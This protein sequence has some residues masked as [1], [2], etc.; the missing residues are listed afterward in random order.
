MQKISRHCDV[1]FDNSD[2]PDHKCK[3]RTAREM[4]AVL[5]L[6][7]EEEMKSWSIRGHDNVFGHLN[8]GEAP[9]GIWGS[10]P[11]DPTHAFRH[12]LMAY[13]LSILFSNLNT[14]QLD[15]IDLYGRNI[16]QQCRQSGSKSFPR[17]TFSHGITSLTFM[18]H[19]EKVGITMI[20]AMIMATER[21]HE[22]LIEDG[23]FFETADQVNDWLLLFEMFLCFDAWTH[24]GTMWQL[25]VDRST[26]EGEKNLDASIRHMLSH[27]SRTCERHEGNAWKLPKY[28]E[29]LHVPWYISLFGHPMNF[30]SGRCEHNHIDLCKTPGATAQKRNDVFE[31]QTGMR[32]AHRY[33][34]DKAKRVWNI[35]EDQTEKVGE[36]NSTGARATRF[37]V[38]KSPGNND[39]PVYDHL[40][41]GTNNGLLR[42]DQ[43]VVALVGHELIDGAEGVVK[44]MTEY[45]RSGVTYRS[46]PKYR[47]VGPWVDWVFVD[48]Q[49]DD[50]DAPGEIITETYPCK[51]LCFAIRDHPVEMEAEEEKTVDDDVHQQSV[52][53]VV[54][55]TLKPLARKKSVVTEHWKMELAPRSVR[56]GYRIVDVDTFN[57]TAFGLQISDTEALIMKPYDEWASE[58]FESQD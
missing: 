14:K 28:H 31:E 24:H 34:V 2:L 58:F 53:A 39:Q 45:K 19:A 35:E 15:Q 54:Q 57:G 52:V 8:M 7:D 26:P 16:I 23:P 36:D 3:K 37:D 11:I 27:L 50:P 46:H 38:S 29:H 10:T 32:L 21:G 30:D 12:G 51:L 9:Y 4:E 48:F 43:D 33:M 20:M 13:A 22:I 49:V 56:P 25:N 42:V 5:L 17:T 40:F 18:T 6:R 55:C 47:S 41:Y 1:S 44:C